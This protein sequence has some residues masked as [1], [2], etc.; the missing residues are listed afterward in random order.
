MSAGLYLVNGLLF[1]GEE[2]TFPQLCGQL[3]PSGR[4]D[5]L[6]DEYG[7]QFLIN[8]DGLAAA[9]KAQAAGQ[10]R[11]DG[12]RTFPGR[13]SDGGNMG[14]GCSAAA[15]N[16]GCT[17]SNEAWGPLPKIGRRHREYGAAVFQ[18]RHAGIWLYADRLIGIFR[19]DLYERNELFRAKGAID[20][21]DIR[22]QGVQGDSGCLRVGTGDGAA[23]FTVGKLADHRQCAGFP[24]CQQRST[25][26]LDINGGFNDDVVSTGRSECLCLL[27]IR[28]VGI[29]KVQVAQRFYEAS[30]GA[31]GAGNLCPA[32]DGLTYAGYG[33]HIDFPY[34]VLQSVMYELQA[35]GAKG[36]CLDDG[37]ASLC[38]GGMYLPDHFRALNV[39]KLRTLPGQQPGILEHR[40]N[41]TVKYMNHRKI[42]FVCS[43]AKNLEQWPCN[44]Y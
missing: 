30:G 3:F 10:R 11:T 7:G 18:V 9:G 24:G 21:D 40:A 4:I 26:F 15:A 23:I 29:L 32:A 37:R 35:A 28:I 22:A 44:L 19:Q 12:L 8:A 6:A 25:H 20:A 27:V 42:S 16:V 13:G 43:L 14:R 2:G 17:S 5:A 31:H 36:I 38:I 1:Y 34:A 39:H 33:S 41:G